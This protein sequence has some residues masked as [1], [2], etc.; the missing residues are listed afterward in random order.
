[1]VNHIASFAVLV[2]DTHCEQKSIT[3]HYHSVQK[4]SFYTSVT[5]KCSFSSIF[6]ESTKR[7][8]QN[9]LL[10]CLCNITFDCVFTCIKLCFPAIVFVDIKEIMQW[11]SLHGTL[12]HQPNLHR[13]FPKNILSLLVT[14]NTSC[15]T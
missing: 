5:N 13:W 2:Y 15:L 1:M 4:L 9:T 3:E 8:H 10:C 14:I 7:C 12:Q 11:K 6:C